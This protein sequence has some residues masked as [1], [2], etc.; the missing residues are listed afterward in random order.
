MRRPPPGTGSGLI[1]I[2]AL[3]LFFAGLAWSFSRLPKSVYQPIKDDNPTPLSW[4]IVRSPVTGR[5]YEVAEYAAGGSHAYA[6]SMSEVACDTPLT[7]TPK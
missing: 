7:P 5:C 4:S 2:A 1:V 3:V 6:F